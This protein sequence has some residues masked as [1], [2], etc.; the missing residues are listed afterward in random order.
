MMNKA[1][2]HFQVFMIALTIPLSATANYAEHDSTDRST[3]KTF[4]MASK[5]AVAKPDTSA[6]SSASVKV[7][8]I[9]EKS[10]DFEVLSS[11]VTLSFALRRWAGN[12]GYQLVWD[13]Q[14]DF[15]VRQTKYQNTNFEEAVEEVMKDLSLTSYPLHACVY[16]NN[17]IRILH[18]SNSCER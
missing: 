3:A 1:S 13:V 2:N 6:G 9:T 11:D 14:K 18:V 7:M 17:V 12:H 10:M 4:I 15:P 16:K 5:D 8:A